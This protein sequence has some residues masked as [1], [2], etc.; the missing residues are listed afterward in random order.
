MLECAEIADA[1]VITFSCDS[2]V[3]GLIDSATCSFDDGP[4][5]PCESDVHETYIRM[6]CCVMAYENFSVKE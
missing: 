3:G 4:S 5:T 2:L 1:R 6:L